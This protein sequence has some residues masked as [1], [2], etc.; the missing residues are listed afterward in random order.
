MGSFI[1]AMSRIDPIQRFA[2]PN[3]FIAKEDSYDPL[4]KN[5]ALG[6]AYANR[7]VVPTTVAPYAGVTPTLQ[8]ANNGY[9][10]QSRNFTQQQQRP[11]AGKPQGFF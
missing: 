10:Q 6:Q 11:V 5:T 7:N 9:I 3:S 4:M 8:D 1:N 2:G